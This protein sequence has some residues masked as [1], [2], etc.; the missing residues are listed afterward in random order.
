[1]TNEKYSKRRLRKF[2]NRGVH[3]PRRR[4]DYR[5]LTLVSHEKAEQT[6]QAA[7]FLQRGTGYRTPSQWRWLHRRLVWHRRQRHY[8]RLFVG[9]VIRTDRPRRSDR[10]SQRRGSAGKQ[11]KIRWRTK[12]RC[13]IGRSIRSLV[14]VSSRRVCRVYTCT[15]CARQFSNGGLTVVHLL[16]YSSLLT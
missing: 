16:L 13:R 3:L 11:Y 2:K 9:I 7:L 10:W 8:Y 6:R 14:S 12:R 1:M 4:Q 15:G 5:F